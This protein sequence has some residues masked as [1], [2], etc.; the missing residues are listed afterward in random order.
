LILYDKVLY[1]NTGFSAEN[2]KLL[3]LHCRIAPKA[4][5][6]LQVFWKAKMRTIRI[7]SRASKLALVQ[8]SYVSRLLKGLAGELDTSIVKLTT[9]GDRDRSDFLHKSDSVGYFTSEVEK[10]L[11]AGRADIAVH[12]LKDLPTAHTPGLVVAAIPRR[13]CVADALISRHKV[14]SIADLPAGTAVGT[15]SLR[16]IAQIRRL[17]DDLRCVPLRGNLETRL[18]KVSEG[19]VDAAIVA[20]AG[21]KR[22]GLEERVSAVLPP[23]QFLPAPAQGAL[24]VQV[25]S[26]QA[27]LVQLV[28]KL[29]DRA[30]R[31]T[32]ETERHILA[33]IRGGCSI[34]LGVYSRIEGDNILIDALISDVDG[35]K[36]VRLSRTAPLDRARSCAE[37]LAEELLAAGG[38]DIIEQI[39]AGQGG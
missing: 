29:D 30:S 4:P 2:L 6:R 13:E 1:F 23:E 19:V 24:A 14:D 27:E 9:K 35:N 25:R 36:Y 20:F 10:A 26:D 8:S 15:S 22:L 21:L 18:R 7:A 5:L 3:G 16:R 37:Q 31:A 17:R 12:S 39:R 33:T 38:W 34:P 11:L 28:S 32:S